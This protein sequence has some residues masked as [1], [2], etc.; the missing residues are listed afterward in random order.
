MLDRCDRLQIAV[1]DRRAAART[2]MALLGAEPA[3]EAASRHL[4]AKITVLA[5]GESEIELCQPDGAGRAQDHLDRHG[6]GLMTA[7]YSTPDIER[8]SRH[9]E[10]QGAAIVREAGRLF[11]GPPA[12]PGL[13]MVISPSERRRRVGPVSFLYE[14]T[15]TLA[16]DW[17]QAAA[18]YAR[19]FALDASKFSEIGSKRF[20]YQGTLTLFD[21]PHRLDRI[22]LSQIVDPNSAMGRFVARRGDS[23]YM[24]YVETHDLPAIKARLVAGGARYTPRGQDPVIELDGLWVHPKDLHGLLLGVSRTGLAWEWSGRKDLVPPRPQ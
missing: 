23:L 24:A 22:E 20:G 13:P 16:S 8:L 7:G 3:R 4:G 12:T 2:F 11:L 17:R 21:P 10:Q 1:G 18:T 15:N 5:L 6:E 9:L 14:T 19:L